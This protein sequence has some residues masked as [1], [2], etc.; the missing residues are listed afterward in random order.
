MTNTDARLTRPAGIRSLHLGDTKVTY[1]PDGVVQL[2]P[3][4]WLP[5]T[6]DEDWAAHPEYLD[7]DG[8]LVA[9]VG[10]LL[11]EHGDRALLIDAGFGPVTLPAAPGSPVGRVES[12]ALF[13]HLTALGRPPAALEA[14]AIT[15]FHRDHIGWSAQLTAAGVTHLVAEPEW[16]GRHLAVE[17]GVPE[18]TLAAIATDV[19]TVADGEEIFPGVRALFTPGHTVGHAAYVITGGGRSLIAFGDAM[20]TPLQVAHPDWSAVVDHDGQQSAAFRHDLVTRLT[21]PDTLGFGIHFADVPFGRVRRTE[22]GGVAW[23]A[24]DE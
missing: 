20:H 24:V 4:G 13:D 8:Y 21:E 6:T 9:G 15:H 10:G 7:T 18:E 5:A 19:R 11:V 17:H 22:D 16:E 12:G 1:V 2:S 14:V 23:E 3:R